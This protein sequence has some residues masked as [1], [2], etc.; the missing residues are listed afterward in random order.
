[1]KLLLAMFLLTAQM[2]CDEMLYCPLE[3]GGTGGGVRVGDTEDIRHE[4]RQQL[5]RV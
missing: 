2:T 4:C 5:D 1:M 3:S